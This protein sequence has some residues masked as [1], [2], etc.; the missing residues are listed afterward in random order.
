ML[1]GVP[2]CGKSTVA[3]YIAQQIGLPLVIARLDALVSSLLGSTSKN[4]R[5]VFDF[6]DSRPCIL[7]LDE[8]DAI[9][10][11]RDDQHELGE[12]KR[13][14]NSLLQNID[15]L[16]SHKPCGFARQ[17]YLETFPHYSRNWS[18]R[19]KRDSRNAQFF[20]W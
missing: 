4:I 7:F 1:Y 19:G 10:K 9:A 12:L 15:S 6:A 16:S 13:V 18:P 20:H 2:G 3:K 11:A 8:F 17:S 14:I 5:K